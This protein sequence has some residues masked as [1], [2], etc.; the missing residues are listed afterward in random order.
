[1]CPAPCLCHLPT[2]QCLAHLHPS[3][4]MLR[5]LMSLHSHAATT[6]CLAFMIGCLP[7][8]TLTSIA[9]LSCCTPL[10]HLSLLTWF[11]LLSQRSNCLSSPTMTVQTARPLPPKSAAAQNTG[12]KT[13]QILKTI[14]TR[15]PV[16]TAASR[17]GQSSIRQNDE[18]VFPFI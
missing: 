8:T 7:H 5:A 18:N 1:M 4:L 10:T 6:P 15:R 17:M 2:I 16:L 12:R 11:F 14:R 3:K 9:P 13:T